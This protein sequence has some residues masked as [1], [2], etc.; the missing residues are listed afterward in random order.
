[1]D[2][3]RARGDRGA[4][5]PTKSQCT[6]NELSDGGGF[7]PYF[8]RPHSVGIAARCGRCG[9]EYSARRCSAY[10]DHVEDFNSQ[11]SSPGNMCAA[12]AAN[13]ER[14]AQWVGHFP[15]QRRIP[16]WHRH[17]V[18]GCPDGYR[19]L[20]KWSSVPAKAFASV[21]IRSRAKSNSGA[22][23]RNSDRFPRCSAFCLSSTIG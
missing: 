1:M 20:Q 3:R 5:L 15:S 4:I 18:S 23:D 2:H 7:Y 14:S 9:S 19:F 22:S 11:R 21:V 17:R 8:P 10:R 6:A 12:F 13:N 16:Q